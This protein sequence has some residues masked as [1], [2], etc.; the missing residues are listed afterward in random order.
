MARPRSATRS[1]TSSRV[2]R[3]SVCRDPPHA[4]AAITGVDLRSLAPGISAN[5]IFSLTHALGPVLGTHGNA[6]GRPSSDGEVIPRQRAFGVQGS[7]TLRL[8]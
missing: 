5:G 6:H 2:P 4:S 8:R 3:P 7:R 1:A